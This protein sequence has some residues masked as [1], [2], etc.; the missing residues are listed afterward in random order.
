MPIKKFDNC[1]PNNY[2]VWICWYSDPVLVLQLISTNRK[3]R[4]KSANC[5]NTFLRMSPI[6][7]NMCL[8]ATK[9]FHKNIAIGWT[10]PLN[11]MDKNGLTIKSPMVTANPRTNGWNTYFMRYLTSSTINKI[12]KLVIILRTPNSSC[13]ILSTTFSALKYKITIWLKIK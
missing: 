1:Y 4:N 11:V 12:T 6:G 5:S 9:Q 2:T 8:N 13:H 7:P 3:A 10:I